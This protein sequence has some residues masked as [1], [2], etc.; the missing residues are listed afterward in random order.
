MGTTSKIVSGAG[1]TVIPG[2]QKRS[3]TTA[4]A[5]AIQKMSTLG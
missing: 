5:K 1:E 4:N 2:D 3:A